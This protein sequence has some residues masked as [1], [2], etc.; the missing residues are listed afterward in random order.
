MADEKPSLHI[1][2][3]W[4]RQAQEEKRRLAEQEKQRA[5]SAPPAPAGPP[6]G[7]GAGAGAMPG[8]FGAAGMTGVEDEPTAGR[9]GMRGAA[10]GER[11]EAPPATLAGLVSQLMT[12]TLFYLG[13][14]APRGGEPVVN[15]DMAK[16]NVD[17]LGVLEE[18]TRGNLTPEEKRLLDSV[19][20]ELR[21]RYVSV[22]SQYIT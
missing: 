2:T 15:L 9:A 13:E 1:D 7:A 20:Y 14:L 10:R 6:P 21:M 12:Q 17:L 22:A 5:A 18:K 8:G 16:H 3:D 11:G 4:K 19:L